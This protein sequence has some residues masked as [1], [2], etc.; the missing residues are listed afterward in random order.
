ML[1]GGSVIPKGCREKFGKAVREIDLPIKVSDI[2][3]A[4][5]PLYATAKGSLKMA[6]EE[7][8]A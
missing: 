3:I 8:G 5:K 7:A 2:R 4:E 6:M 1:S